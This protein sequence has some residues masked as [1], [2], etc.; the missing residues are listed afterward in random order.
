MKILFYALRPFDELQYCEPNREKYGIDYQW[1]AEV[2]NPDNLQLAEGCDAVST[3][4]CEIR[5]EYLEAF[6]KMGVKYLPC[7]SIGY[8]HIPLDTAK[9]LGM[10]GQPQPLPAGGSRQLHHHADADGH[11][12]DESDHAARSGPG[13][14]AAR[15]DGP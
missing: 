9:R 14:F 3:N 12:Q 2:P 11:P 5:P 4:P 8:D 6:A 7:R 15:Q 10:A 1:T 13:L